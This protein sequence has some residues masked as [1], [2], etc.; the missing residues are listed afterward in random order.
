MVAAWLCDILRKAEPNGL[1]LDDLVALSRAS[2]DLRAEYEALTL[3]VPQW[4]DDAQRRISREIEVRR[5]DYLEKRLREARRT[6]DSLAGP[7][8]KRAKAADEIKAL[9][10]QLAPSG[11]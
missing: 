9:E 10:S 8:E 1:L 2:K 7:E 5:R 3:E 4:L 6:Y 11:Q